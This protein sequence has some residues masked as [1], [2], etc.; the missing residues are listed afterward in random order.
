MTLTLMSWKLITGTHK[1]TNDCPSQYR[2]QP[3]YDPRYRPPSILGIIATGLFLWVIVVG[4]FS[5]G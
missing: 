5:I 1:M 4:A 3:G 2:K